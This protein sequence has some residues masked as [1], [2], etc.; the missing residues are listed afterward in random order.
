LA[1]ESEQY[2]QNVSEKELKEESQFW[3]LE[4]LEDYLFE[5]VI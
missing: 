2:S 5:S 4:K 1:A 3:S